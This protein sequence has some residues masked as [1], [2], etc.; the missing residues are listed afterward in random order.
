M[1]DAEHLSSRVGI[2]IHG[3][4]AC[5]GSADHLKAL[6]GRGYDVEIRCTPQSTSGCPQATQ[7]AAVG[8][9][10]ASCASNARI[11]ESNNGVLRFEASDVRLHALF[12]ALEARKAE[13][14]I[15]DYAV[16]QT[17]LEQVFLRLCSDT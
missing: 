13:L 12:S 15:V 4:F 1:E 16:S 5:L 11:L 7:E 3:R 17:T 14:G 6:Y 10:V 2:L 9:L 8:A